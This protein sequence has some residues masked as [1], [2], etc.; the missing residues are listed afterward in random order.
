VTKKLR[1]AVLYGGVSPEHDISLLSTSELIHNLDQSRFDIIPI[2]IDK[3]G[4]WYLN[5][6]KDIPARGSI[7]IRMGNAEVFSGP[8]P[9][10]KSFGSLCDV[11]F[12]MIH[13]FFGEDGRIQGLFDTLRLPY[14]GSGVLASALAMDKELTKRLAMTV[15]IPIVPF[16]TLYAAQFYNQSTVCIQKILHK[17]NL[18]VFI[19]PANAG[20][21]LGVSKVIRE[22]ELERSLI[23]AFQYDQKVLIERAIAAREIEVAVLGNLNPLEQAFVSIAGEIIPNHEFY[24]YEAKYLD[25]QGARLIIPAPLQ[26]QIQERIRQLAGELFSLLGCAGMARVD[27]FL[28]K[29]NENNIFFNEIN[30]IPGFTKISMYPK[31]WEASGR[32]YSSLLTYLIELA[33]QRGCHAQNI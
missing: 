33:M 21:S 13:G 6:S 16:L 29:E 28:D 19:K 18:P 11:I 22:E 12:P 2:G 23:M 17:F 15:N 32:S 1:V 3:D 26:A 31:L 4:Q 20:S 7:S 24:S 10:L 9:L 27:F 30:T 25:E 5:H 8:D 14:V